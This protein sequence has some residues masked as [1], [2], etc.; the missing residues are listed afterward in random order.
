M[1]Q[2]YNRLMHGFCENSES[3]FKVELLH[4]MVEIVMIPDEECCEGNQLSTF[5][6]AKR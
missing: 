2:T 3:S 1:L 6:A 5:P 4:K